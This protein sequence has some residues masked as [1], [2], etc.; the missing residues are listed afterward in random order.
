MKKFLKITGVVL[1]VILL[2]AGGMAFYAYRSAGSIPEFYKRH[3]PTGEAR[4]AALENIERKM[5]NLQGRF[6]QAVATNRQGENG[7][8]DAVPLEPVEIAFSADELDVTLDGW[9][10]S[11]GLKERMEAYLE[12][13]RLAL[14]DDHLVLAGT[15]PELGGRVVSIHLVPEVADNGRAR[16]TLD[17]IYAGRL[18]L[19]DMVMAPM[20]DRSVQALLEKS[21]PLR[22]KAAIDDT[23]AA[24]SEAAQVATFDQ[25]AI[26]LQRQPLDEMVLFPRLASGDAVPA[27]V[28]SLV[29]AEGNLTL[30]FAPLPATERSELLERIQTPPE[31]KPDPEVEGEA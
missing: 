22:D 6:D 12:D 17:G 31:I 29:I 3:R 15:M 13:P 28:E 7:D 21:A 2:A 8:T 16:L 30:G 14:V 20:R 26:L 10:A 24:N 25:L 19:P 4:L 5:M 1:V 18:S 11:S 23:G 27:R 9:L